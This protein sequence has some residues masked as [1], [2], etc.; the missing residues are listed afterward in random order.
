MPE[1]K[2]TEER[3]KGCEFCVMYCPKN[4]LKM[5]SGFN[6]KGY[7]YPEY[8]DRESCNGCAICGRICPE[9]ALEVYK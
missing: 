8:A 7:H 6:A 1:I 9:V 3:C 2:V 5:S 4:T